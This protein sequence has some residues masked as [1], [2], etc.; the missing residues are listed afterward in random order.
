MQQQMKNNISSAMV[1]YEAATEH[2][3][4]ARER[5]TEAK[6]SLEQN[7]MSI[8]TNE[9]ELK[10]IK[11]ALSA[12]RSA[13]QDYATKQSRFDAAYKDFKSLDPN[14]DRRYVIRQLR[15]ASQEMAVALPIAEAAVNDNGLLLSS[16]TRI[17]AG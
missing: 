9:A 11:S 15:N 2:L 8:K 6:A 10:S 17:C 12:L 16:G 7:Q 5:Y 4:Q 3:R 14:S 1:Q 13:K